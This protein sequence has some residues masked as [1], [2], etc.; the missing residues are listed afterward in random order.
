MFGF[1][2]LD[3]VP[4]FNT[5]LTIFSSFFYTFRVDTNSDSLNLFFFSEIEDEETLL[6][7][8]A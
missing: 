2:R 8:R 7:E 5:T 3:N 4:W 1:D 6:S